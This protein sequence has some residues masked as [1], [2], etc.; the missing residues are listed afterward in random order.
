MTSYE[1]RQLREVEREI[2]KRSAA[3]FARDTEGRGEVSVRRG[4]ASM[5]SCLLLGETVG[6]ASPGRASLLREA[7]A[8]QRSV[9]TAD[10]VLSER[11]GCSTAAGSGARAS[12]KRPIGIVSSAA[13]DPRP[14]RGGRRRESSTVCAKSGWRDAPASDFSGTTPAVAVTDLEARAKYG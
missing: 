13:A 9:G 11:I 6:V 1:W 5:I 7:P 3:F 2:L 14:G 12:F 8:G 10:A 4:G